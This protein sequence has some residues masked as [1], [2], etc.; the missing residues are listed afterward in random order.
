MGSVTKIT[1]GVFSDLFSRQ[2]P[3]RAH[4]MQQ[5]QQIFQRRCELAMTALL[6]LLGSDTSQVEHVVSQGS[7]KACCQ[8]SSHCPLT[9]RRTEKGPSGSQMW[10]SR[11]LAWCRLLWGHDPS[12][13]KC[14]D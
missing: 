13:W 11:G 8:S 14:W 3:W 9:E 7:P 10:E 5:A 1:G 12:R 4:G 6:Y 2:T